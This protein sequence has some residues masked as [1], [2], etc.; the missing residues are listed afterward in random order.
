MAYYKV[1]VDARYIQCQYRKCNASHDF[2]IEANSGEEAQKKAEEKAGERDMFDF[3]EEFW[4]DEDPEDD[5]FDFEVS[6]TEEL[7]P[8]NDK[9]EIEENLGRASPSPSKPPYAH[10]NNF[11]KLL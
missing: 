3:I 5:N 2:Y 1:S 11:L 9:D 4:E 7:D 10:Y 8:V 6:E